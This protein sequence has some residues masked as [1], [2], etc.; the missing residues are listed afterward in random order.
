MEV[1]KI[2]DKVIARFIGT[3][4]ERDIKRISPMVAEVNALEAELKALSD[5]ELSA[6]TP[7]LRAEVAKRLE[8]ANPADKDYKN[9]LQAALEPAVVPAFALVREAAQAEHAAFRCAAYR[10]NCAA[11]RQDCG[12]ED[13]RRQD[14][15]GDAAGVLERAGRA[16]RTYCDGERLPGTS[17]RG[18]DEPD[19]QAA[20]AYGRCDRSRPGRRAAARGI[21]G[22]YHVRNEQRA[23]L[24]LSARQHEVRPGGLRTA[25]APVLHRGRSG[26]DFD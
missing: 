15:G 19:L 16:R 10:R 18:M 9:K 20:G 2:L 21:R 3:K 7:Q 23:G 8:G 6:R 25:R 12:N 17:R 1:D 4:H 14:A 22:G 5:A 11:P 26:L 13:R 24:R